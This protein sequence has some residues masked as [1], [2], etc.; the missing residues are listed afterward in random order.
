MEVSVLAV[1]RLAEVLSTCT[2]VNY[3][4]SRG[5]FISWAK[6]RRAGWGDV[7]MVDVV[8]PPVGIDNLVR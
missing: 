7:D 5:L 8:H 4:E 1:G 3:K 6:W 2:Y